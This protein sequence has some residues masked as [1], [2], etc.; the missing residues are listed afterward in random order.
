M[1]S[2]TGIPQMLSTLLRDN[3][4][5]NSQTGKYFLNLDYDDLNSFD[6]GRLASLLKAHPNQFIPIVTISLIPSNLT[7]I[8]SFLSFFKP[9]EFVESIFIV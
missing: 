8:F 2:H 5:A 6:E 4:I 7:T 3:L 1:S 9:E